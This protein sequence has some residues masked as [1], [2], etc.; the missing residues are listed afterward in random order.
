MAVQQHRG[1]Q[2]KGRDLVRD[3]RAGRFNKLAALLKI[4]LIGLGVDGRVD[5]R[6]LAT[7]E[8]P[9][10]RTNLRV[11]HGPQEQVWFG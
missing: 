6:V 2:G 5:L 1:V 3:F 4:G 10:N 7:I 8:Y 11:E 9:A